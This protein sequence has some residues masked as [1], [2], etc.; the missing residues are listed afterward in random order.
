VFPKAGGR[1]SRQPTTF[2]LLGETVP[3]D[4]LAALFAG[5]L[6]QEETKKNA[7]LAL[8]L[9][10][11]FLM[12]PGALKE[13]VISEVRSRLP[14]VDEDKKEANANVIRFDLS[15]AASFPADAPRELWLDHAIVRN[16]KVLSRRSSRFS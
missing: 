11:A 9:V 5:G 15:L 4:D 14:P 10:D 3:K 6:N 12:T 16:F 13:S 8:E 7:E 2:R 1:S